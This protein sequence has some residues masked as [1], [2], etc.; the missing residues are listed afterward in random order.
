MPQNPLFATKS[1]A[2]LM[3]EMKGENRLRRVLGP[4]ALTA[5]RR[6]RDHRRR[7]LRAHRGRRARQGGAGAHPLLRPRRLRLR[8]RGALLRGVRLDDSGRGLGLHVRLRDAR[9]T[10]RLDHRVGPRP[11]V[12][13]G[14][15]HRRERLVALLS[16][17]SSNSLASSCRTTGSRRRSFVAKAGIHRPARSSICLPPSSSVLVTIILVIGIQRVRPLQCHDGVHQARSRPLRDLRRHLL[18]QRP[19][20]GTRSPRMPRSAMGPGRRSACS[21]ARDHLLRVHRLRFDLD[22]RR[23]GEEPEAR[24]PIGILDVAWRLHGP[25]HRGC[26]RPHGNGASRPDRDQRARRGGVPEPGADDGAVFLSRPARVAGITSV[27]LVMMLSAAARPP[28][29][30]ARRHL[31]PGFFGA[32]HPKFRTPWKSTIATGVFVLVMAGLFLASARSPT[33]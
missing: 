27:L 19:R 18:H 21:R 33:W 13:D 22:A 26:R 23:R 15:G 28:G 9:R 25:L 14:L 11:R 29:D 17:S 2:R 16:S 10:P 6:G 31:P 7:N 5:P 20:T 4:V 3:E 12:R 8:L 30:G 1:M 32:V 24:R